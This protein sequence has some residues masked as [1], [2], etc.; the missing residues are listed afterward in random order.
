MIEDG[1]GYPPRRLVLRFWGVVYAVKE[2]G[3]SIDAF[4][5]ELKRA[6]KWWWAFKR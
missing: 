3:E 1:L 4:F 5:Q 2:L 6:V